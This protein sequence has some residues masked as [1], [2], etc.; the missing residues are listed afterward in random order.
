VEHLEHFGLSRDPFCNDPQVATYFEGAEHSQAERR[1]VRAVSQNKGLV[2]FTGPRGSGKSMIVRHLLDS[3]EEE[4]YE[5]CLLLPVPSVADGHWVL[6]RLAAQLGVES[7]AD[8]RGALL[9]QVYEAMA[10]V[11][12]DG[13]HTVLFVDE[14]EVLA[15]RGALGALQALL[16]LEYEERRLLTLVLV[17]V[18]ELDDHIA[19]E[20]GL[21]DRVDVHVR[22]R[23]LDERGAQAYLVHRIR[24]VGGSPAIID[25]GALPVLIERAGGVPRRMN[26]IADN[27]LFEAFLASRVSATAEDVNRAADELSLGARPEGAGAAARAGAGASGVIDEMPTA[28]PARPRGM[29]DAT[30]Q[31]TED[32]DSSIF[33]SSGSAAV[34][35]PGMPDA[36]TLL[37]S[38]SPTPRGMPDATMILS[39]EDDDDGL[40]GFSDPIP[41]PAAPVDGPPKDDEIDDLF[42]D[43]VEDD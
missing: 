36:R 20:R 16:N 12:E 29:P 11:R 14:T 15:D 24:R 28:P 18:P 35:S 31:L 25:P 42:V 27:A 38:S 6:A 21:A 4:V 8:E 30:M 37:S 7:A 23:A 41:E 5:A 1:L 22:L 10:V 32:D 17:G 40:G 9:G 39:A 3:L 13:R 34:D 43:L 26:T 33:S 2:L 19:A